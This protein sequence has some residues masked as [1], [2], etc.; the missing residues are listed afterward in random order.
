MALTVMSQCD[1][2]HAHLL[3]E[4]PILL[5]RLDDNRIRSKGDCH[6]STHYTDSGSWIHGC[7]LCGYDGHSVVYCATPSSHHKV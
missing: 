1:Q 4:S 5:N 6:A 7:F 2:D 3:R